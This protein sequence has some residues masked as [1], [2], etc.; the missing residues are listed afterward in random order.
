MNKPLLPIAFGSLLLAAGAAWAEAESA[1]D[2]RP[3][4]S[5]QYGY[6]FEDSARTSE[7]GD[8][9][10]LAGTWNFSPRWAMELGASY[11]G[12]DTGLD[13]NGIARD[14]RET[15]LSV[16]AQYYLSRQPRFSPYLT[17][18][19]GALRLEDR[20]G[21][22][23]STDP[24]GEVGVGFR[25]QLSGRFGVRG[26]ATY[27]YIDVS[28]DRHASASDRFQ[29]PV[30]RLGFYMALGAAPTAEPAAPAP[31]AAPTPRPLTPAPL[32]EPAPEVIF[33]FDEA[34]FFGFDSATLRPEAESKLMEAAQLIQQ[35][36]SLVKVE[37]AGHTC[38]IGSAPYNLGLSERRAR[39]VQA[40]LVNQGGIDASR[41]MV[42]GYGVTRPKV[43]NTS[44]E[45]R[46]MNRR[47]ELIA[48][49]RQ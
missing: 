2:L 26:D 40:F 41:L 5:L 6:V 17:A 48:N 32:A 14:W 7:N 43:P 46:Q 16:G 36:A 37:I 25:S 21:D 11:H 42:T 9:A 4:L 19:A 1:T 20:I 30:V 27:R 39:A 28:D 38:D 47:V 18:S 13:D 8:G 44:A 24:F 3:Q 23:R 45:N 31:V 15:G 33:E 34:I 35:D 49:E 10:Y 22:T 29:E 12:F